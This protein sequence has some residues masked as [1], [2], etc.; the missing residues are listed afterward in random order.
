MALTAD[1][2]GPFKW[3]HQVHYIQQKINQDKEQKSLKT[4]ANGE[5]LNK[6]IS[7]FHCCLKSFLVSN[8]YWFGPKI[9]W[10]EAMA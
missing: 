2:N 3:K 1:I 9:N 10:S 8:Y 7:T 4:H 6:K 5:I